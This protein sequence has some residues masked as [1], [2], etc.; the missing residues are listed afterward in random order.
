MAVSALVNPYGVSVH[1][2]K[3]YI[4]MKVKAYLHVDLER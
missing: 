3:G 1:P 4:G 2:V